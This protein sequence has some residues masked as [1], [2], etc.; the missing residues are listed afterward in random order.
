MDLEEWPERA[1]AYSHQTEEAVPG[2]DTQV[3]VDEEGRTCGGP[4]TAGSDSTVAPEAL[5]DGWDMLAAAC[6]SLA[7]L[8][9]RAGGRASTANAAAD[10]AGEAAWS[11]A[12]ACSAIQVMAPEA[13][14][15][16]QG[17]VVE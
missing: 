7:D 4:G 14:T 8:H 1:V 15:A 12:H 3:E 6:C 10:T 9:S 2:T 5:A 17:E 13:G 16:Y 11:V